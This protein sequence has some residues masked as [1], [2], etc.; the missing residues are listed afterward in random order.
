[1]PD[2]QEFYDTTLLDESKSVQEKTNETLQIVAKWEESMTITG[3]PNN[4][5]YQQQQQQSQQQPPSLQPEVGVRSS[6]AQA[7]VRS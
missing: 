7:I 6:I 2:I 5:T 4:I 3:V 1:M